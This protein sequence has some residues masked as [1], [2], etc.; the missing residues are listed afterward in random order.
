M[1]KKEI[2]YV[3]ENT[4]FFYFL[5]TYGVCKKKKYCNRMSEK[6]IRSFRQMFMIYMS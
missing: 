6:K 2:I 3:F 4:I 5:I 1:N